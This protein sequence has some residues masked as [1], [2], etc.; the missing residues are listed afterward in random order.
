M[1]LTTGQH[2]PFVLLAT[3]GT[4]GHITPAEAL[5]K[6]LLDHGHRVALATDPRAKFFNKRTDLS[7]FQ[8]N[9]A[10]VSGKGIIGKITATFKLIHGFFQARRLLKQDRPSVVVAFGGYSSIPISLAAHHQ[11][12]PLILHEQNGVLG[13]ANRLLLSRASL[14]ATSFP[15]VLGIPKQ[16]YEKVVLT[17]NPVRDNIIETSKTASYKPPLS[18]DKIN[19]FVVGGSQGARR[20]AQVV[21]QAISLLPVELQKRLH[22]VQQARKEN[23]KPVGDLYHS[24]GIEVELKEFFE[25]IPRRLSESHLVICRAGAA[26]IAE[27][28]VMG[29]P[30]IYVPFPY[31]IY[32]H[33]T[34]NASIAEE[35]GAGWLIPQTVLNPQGLADLLINF[36]SNPA[37]LTKAAARAKAISRPDAAKRL[38]EVV[39]KVIESTS[40]SKGY[41]S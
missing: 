34:I 23:M 21:P 11:G 28:L 25:N 39:E 10:G 35:A 6:E 14:V 30:A 8:V 2:K 37:L 27:V 7:V 4:G 17:G 1:T 32:D 16:Q 9:S 3:G 38:A 29:R 26:T 41:I 20:F 24:L 13:R 22:I 40:A 18:T 19:I 33:Q 12:I 36:T 31:S 15:R 5:A